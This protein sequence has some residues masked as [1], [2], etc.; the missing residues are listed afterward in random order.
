MRSGILFR[1]NRK[2]R[3]DRIQGINIVRP[4]VAR[5]FGAA[6]VEISQAGQDAQ[7]AVVLPRL[8]G[9]GW[10]RREILRLASGTHTPASPPPIAKNGQTI[11]EGRVEEFFTPE[12]DPDTAPPESVVSLNVGRLAGSLVFSGGTVFLVLLVIG[13]AFWIT[14]TGSLYVLFLALP[15]L[16]G[17]GSYYLS[18]V[19]RSLQYT[20]A[21]TPDGCGSASGCSPRPAR[22]CR[23]GASTRSR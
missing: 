11:F 14:T 17:F 3:L 2:A 12:L 6:K 23:P 8:G 21:G 18:K 19:T 22:S 15:S 13:G 20:I 9:C 7:C 16:I 4:F 10:L 1:T 5:L